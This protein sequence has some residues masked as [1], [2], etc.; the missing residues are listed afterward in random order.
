MVEVLLREI[1][2][3]TQYEL[4]NFVKNKMNELKLDSKEFSNQLAIEESILNDIINSELV[5]KKK[6]YLA[7]QSILDIKEEELFAEAEKPTEIHYR[8][9]S[10]SDEVKKVVEK[11]DILFNE[12]VF[13][14]KIFGK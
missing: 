7:I 9:S 14:K 8:A 12:W 5:F 1:P 13:Q 2:K 3:Y 4:S 10:H 11:V 6:H